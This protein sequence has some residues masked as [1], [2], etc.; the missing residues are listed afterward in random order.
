M[1]LL[2]IRV[3]AEPVR[4]LGFAS[5]AVG[6]M[7][8][9]TAIAH[10]A[11]QIFIQNLTDATLMFSLN[12]VDDHF[13]LPANGFFLDDIVSNKSL[14]QGLFLA[15]G[16]RLYVKELGVPTSGSVYFTVF[17]ASEN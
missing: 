16:D 5:I 12:G 15:Q 13:P 9:G 17:Y 3:R 8:V 7:G 6:Y 14:G 10:P 11:S 2:A 1:S 4:S